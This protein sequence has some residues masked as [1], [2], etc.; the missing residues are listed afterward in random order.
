MTCV[1][2]RNTCSVSKISGGKLI[3][4]QKDIKLRHTYIHGLYMYG[5]GL[6]INKWM[7]WN[8]LFINKP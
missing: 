7:D 5:N 1:T 8:G 4:I 6:F 2:G 3:S